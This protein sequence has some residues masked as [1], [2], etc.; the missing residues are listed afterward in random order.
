MKYLVVTADDFGLA[1]EVNEA[2]I[3]A[4]Q[5]GILTSASLMVAAP[6]ARQAILLAKQHPSLAVGLHLVLAEGNS[7]LSNSTIPDLVDD[8]KRFSNHLVT[9]GVRYFFS[10]KL[11]RQLAQECEAQIQE[12]LATGLKLDHLNSHNHLHIHPTIVKILLP[13]IQKYRIPAV[14]FPWQQLSLAP[15]QQLPMALGMAPWAFRLKAKF[16]G[17]VLLNEGLF[18]LYESG[19]LTEQKWLA[20]LPKIKEGITEIYCHPATK[21][22]GVLRQTMP[23]YRHREEWLA[24]L[25]PTVREQINSSGIQLTT[26]GN[27]LET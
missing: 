23:R 8:S 14:R 13:L 17:K 7:V 2:V 20:L 16:K 12:F 21:T 27:L 3:E 24:L 6:A 5:R 10:K 25:S 1:P 22:D 26:W 15:I 9:T 4:H 19:G 11:K 18:G